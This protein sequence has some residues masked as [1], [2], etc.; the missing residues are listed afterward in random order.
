MNKKILL[1]LILLSIF[2]VSNVSAGNDSNISPDNLTIIETQVTEE[3]D[4]NEPNT[5]YI[6]PE[7]NIQDTIDQAVEGDTIVL[8]GTFELKNTIN[9]DKTLNIRGDGNGATIKPTE[10]TFKDLRLFNIK[11]TA[12]NVILSNLKLYGGK[13]N[14]GAAILW[15]GNAGTLNNCEI[16]QNTAKESGTILLKGN[17]CKITDST[18][19]TNKAQIAGAILIEGDDCQIVNCSFNENSAYKYGGAILIESNNCLITE[20]TFN[21]NFA[22]Q[23]GGA[24]VL[25][26][27]GNT[28]SNSKFDQNYL[29]N[30]ENGSDITGG[31]AIFSSCEN[32]EIDNCNFN[33]NNALNLNGGA[34]SLVGYGFIRNSSFK[35]NDALFG[36]AIYC[37]SSSTIIS[38]YFAI[39]YNESKEDALN[40]SEKTYERENIFNKTKISSSVDFTASMIFEYG[41]SGSVQVIV[42]GGTVQ[43][44]NIRVLNH[45]EAKI[46]FS[47]SI[48]T[49]SGLGVGNYILRVTTTPDENHTAI[50]KDLNIT[51]KKAVAV[52]SASKLTVA[53]KSSS[54]WSIKIINSK[55]NKPIPKMKLTLKVY[56]GKK[57]KTTT[58]TTNSKGVASYKTKSLGA[59]THKIVVSGTHSGYK[60]NTLTS[61]IKVIKQTAL[62]FKLQART[63]D[64]NGAILSYIVSNKKT[65]NGINGVKIKFLI[66]TGKKYKT[67]VLKTK[68]IKG[69]TKIYNGAIGFATNEFSAGTHKVKILPYDLKYKGSATSSIVI[70]KSATKGLKFFRSI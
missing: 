43:K 35:D 62:K 5:H 39:K 22:S 41:A 32:T 56:T 25:K 19:K 64:K 27:K 36:N 28:I 51:V 52:I 30:Y 67:F 53:L 6:T 47:K 45:K 26:G 9:I 59:G 54:I 68:K 10:T 31:G 63:S 18:F 16:I 69:S 66:Y 60:F 21:N 15:E 38:N 13:E 61:S 24:I 2:T 12:S 57:Y 70:K 49:I 33:G 48:L 42:D 1:I 58:V 4:V 3:L 44:E 14:Y 29:R 17:N 50:D 37:N 11:N 40:I 55:T 65:N 46:T 34:I 7:S 8:N 20:C 23:S